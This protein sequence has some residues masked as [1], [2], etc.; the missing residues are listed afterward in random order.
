MSPHRDGI[1]TIDSEGKTIFARDLMAE[2]LGTTAAE[3]IGQPSFDFVFP[4]DADAAQRLF[5]AKQRGDI[6]PFEFR[7]RRLDSSP[8]FVR[9]QGTPM[10]DDDGTFR[11][12][13][14]T[15]SV[16]HDRSADMAA[17]GTVMSRR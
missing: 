11:G 13:V 3:M 8:V 16:I 17:S 7:I 10:F 1:W 6:D 5:Q 14:G 4:E 9:I 2:I 12:I 15:F